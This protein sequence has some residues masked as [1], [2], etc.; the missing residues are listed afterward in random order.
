[1]A[2]PP[3]TSFTTLTTPE[4]SSYPSPSTSDSS[5]T[6][7]TPYVALTTPFKAPGSC[8]QDFRHGSLT[9]TKEGYYD[10]TSVTILNANISGTYSSCFPSGFGTATFYPAVCPSGWTYYT[11]HTPQEGSTLVTLANKAITYEASTF[12]ACCAR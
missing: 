7:S 5:T 8:F 4:A 12:A 3:A 1:M 9:V 10:E 2:T 6:A 11:I